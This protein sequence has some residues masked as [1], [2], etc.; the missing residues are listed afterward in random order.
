MIKTRKNQKS[1][2]KFLGSIETV[3]KRSDSK[4]LLTI[5]EQA[6]G[7]QP[8]MWGERIVGFGVYHYKSERSSQERDWFY[9]GFSPTKQGLSIY[10]MSLYDNYGED[11]KKLGK[12]NKGVCC[13]RVKRLSDIDI[14]V[15]QKIIKAATKDIKKM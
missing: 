1:V 15:L 4:E 7:E 12:H 14:K 6:T 5:L 10:I 11:L 2:V 9:V 8:A 13:L 3:E